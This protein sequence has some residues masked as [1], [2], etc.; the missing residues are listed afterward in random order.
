MDAYVRF[1]LRLANASLTPPSPDE[2]G[3]FSLSVM[4]EID[5][6]YTLQFADA[7]ARSNTVWQ[8]LMTIS[9]TAGPVFL[10]DPEATNL[11]RRFY[12]VKVE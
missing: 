1:V 6:S 9:N 12:R 10:T 7:L 8:S 5:R 3:A 2:S 11:F 4:A